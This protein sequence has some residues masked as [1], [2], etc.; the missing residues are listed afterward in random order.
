[1]RFAPGGQRRS[2]AFARQ[3][4]KMQHAAQKQQ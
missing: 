1:M 2:S 3:L 4:Q